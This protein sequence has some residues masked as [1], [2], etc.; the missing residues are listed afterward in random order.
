[1]AC[2]SAG[3]RVDEDERRRRADEVGD[4]SDILLLAREGVGREMVKECEGVVVSGGEEGAWSL[5]RTTERR[6]KVEGL[7]ERVGGGEEA[8]TVAEEF[9]EGPVSESASSD[10]RLSVVSEWTSRWLDVFLRLSCLSFSSPSSSS[11]SSSPST[12]V[13]PPLSSSSLLPVR[14]ITTMSLFFLPPSDESREMGELP[15][16]SGVSTLRQVP[17]ISVEG[18][19]EPSPMNSMI[20]S[21][22][23]LF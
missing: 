2:E 19:H 7:R 8:E 14:S 21:E 17:E 4:V 20:V 5:W 10:R 6:G 13:V 23:G 15:L 11:S 16:F 1:V 9:E 12:C 3:E 18:L 22:D